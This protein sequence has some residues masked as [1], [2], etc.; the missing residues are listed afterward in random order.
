MR[1]NVLNPDLAIMLLDDAIADAQAQARTFAHWFCGIERI[2]SAIQIGKSRPRVF[3][4]ENSP[5]ATR[6]GA[7]G[8]LSELGLRLY[9]VDGVVHQVQKNLFELVLVHRNLG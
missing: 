5:I 1:L 8:D 2:Q 4:L 9:G 7:D 3:D 6:E